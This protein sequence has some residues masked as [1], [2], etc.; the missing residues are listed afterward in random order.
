MAQK[1]KKAT[2]ATRPSPNVLSSPPTAGTFTAKSPSSASR[3]VAVVRAELNGSGT[4]TALGFTVQGNTPVLAL[5][6]RLVEAGYDPE[7]LL[8]AWRSDVLCLRVRSICE[9]ASLE[10]NG[11]GTGF[12]R[13]RAPD[14]APPMRKS[15]RVPD[16]PGS[17]P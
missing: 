8:E 14:A 17:A 3:I 16:R 10:I 7:T 9:G 13:R 6:R 1:A 4:A 12:R 5:C 2:L 15:T 11:D